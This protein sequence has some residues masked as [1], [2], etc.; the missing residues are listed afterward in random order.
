[1]T[2][3][4]IH[5]CS[6]TR[7][8][9]FQALASN[10]RYILTPFS[11]SSLLT[12]CNINRYFDST[13]LA[14]SSILPFLRS[15]IA[16]NELEREMC[17]TSF[18]CRNTSDHNVVNMA[19]LFTI[20]IDQSKE[21]NEVVTAGLIALAFTL[22]KTHNSAALP[23]LG[24]K[25]LDKF[26]RKRYIYGAGV[27]KSLREFL[28]ADQEASQYTE[29]LT[30]LSTTNTLTISECVGTIREVIDFFLLI[31]GQHAMRMMQFLVPILKMS[32][33]I[34][35]HFIE[36]MRKAMFQSNLSTRQAG[37][38]G[39]CLILKELRNNNSCRG[40]MSLGASQFVIS[41]YSLMS[42]QASG[43]ENSPNRH[44]DMT[45]LEIVGILRK[46]FNQTYEIKEMLY[47]SLINT[48][49]HNAKLVPHILQ[50]LECHFRNY[51]EVDD[52]ELEILFDKCI[53]EKTSGGLTTVQVWDNVGKLLQLVARCI[54]KCQQNEL[55]SE[56][57]DLEQLLHQIANEIEN[58]TDESL[59][60]KGN[61]SQKTCHVGMQY[62]NCIEGLMYFVL[63]VENADQKSLE[64]V[65]LLYEA[66][67]KRSAAF[68]VC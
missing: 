37:I 28:F 63:N 3:S 32:S 10:P 50:F 42:Q 11:I 40:N 14:A 9:Y 68:T 24:M 49:E 62:L 61:L 17:G 53:V 58:V 41:G 7:L 39:F 65:F 60:L 33:V 31:P 13:R 66:H 57:G 51:F 64:S 23:I 12:M 55:D 46:C 48:I 16:N 1:M 22:L 43:N 20:L 29:V 35:D 30:L 15:V 8:E 21:G 52:N 34:R 19:N 56:T 44:F 2:K 6:F 54:L 27:L 26:I 18:W 47:D 38:F 25:F 4:L 45:V 5:F 59:G 36:T 67:A